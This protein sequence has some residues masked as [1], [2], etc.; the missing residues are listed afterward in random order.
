MATRQH[1]AG[2]FFLLENPL[3]SE[4]WQQPHVVRLA[5]LPGVY[6]FVLD[7][8]EFGGQV[9]GH[10]IIKPFKIM[11]DFPGLRDV[12]ERRL[13]PEERSNCAPIEGSLTSG[14]QAYPEQMCRTILGH[15]REYVKTQQPARF[16]FYSQ[17]LPVQ[18]PTDDLSQWDEIVEH[19]AKTFERSNRRPFTM[20]LDSELGRKI[21]DLFRIDAIKIQAVSG[22]TTRRIPSN[23]DEYYTRAAFFFYNDET[24]AVEVED[25]GD[26]QFPRQ[27]FSKPV[28]YAI[29]EPE[30]SASTTQSRTPTMVPNLP[31]DIDFPDLSKDVPQE[32]RSAVARLHLN[33]GHPSR[34]ELN[35]LLA[36]EGNFPD[37][38]YECARKLR[39]STCERLKPKQPPRPTAQ[40][41]MVVGQFGDEL[42]MDIFYCKTLASE[43]FMV[44]G[45]VDRATGLHQAIILPDRNS[46]TTFDCF[47]KVWLRPFGLP[48]HLSCDPDKSFRGSFESRVQAMGCIIEHC[49]PEAHYVIGMVERRNALLRIILEKFIYQFAASTVDQCSAL[50]A[51]SSHAINTGIHT[52]GRSAYQAVFGRQPRLLNGNLN[53]PMVLATSPS[54]AQVNQSAGFRAEFIRCEALKRLHELDCSQHLRR[55]LLR[56]TR[57]TKIADLQP[58]QAC[59]YWRWTRRGAKKRGGWV[60][61]RFLSWDPSHVGKQA[62]LRTGASTTLVTA[63]QL[64]AAFG[65]EDWVPDKEDVKA[66]KD[67]ATKFESFLDDRGPDPPQDQLPEDDELEWP[68]EQPDAE[69]P[70]TPSM[71][72][73]APSTPAEPSFVPQP[74]PPQQPSTPILLPLSGQQQLSL[75]QQQISQQQ[76][77]QFNIDS[78]TNI[79]QMI[80]QQYHRYGTVPERSRRRSRTPTLKRYGSTAAASIAPQQPEQQALPQAEQTA[81]AEQPAL[82]D[83]QHP[84]AEQTAGEEFVET[85][86]TPAPVSTQ[87]EVS[88]HA[89]ILDEQQTEHNTGDTQQ[90]QAP[91]DTQQVVV[92]PD[93]DVQQ[94]SSSASSMSTGQLPQKRPFDTMF[95]LVM[96]E[97]GNITTPDASWDGS[98]PIGFVPA[99]RLLH[100]AYLSSSQRLEDVKDIGKAGDESDTSQES[101]DDDL[102]A[103]TSTTMTAVPVYKQGMSRQE[104]KALDREIPWRRILEMSPSYID[105]FIEAVIKA[106]ESWATWESVQP[107]GAFAPG[108]ATGTRHWG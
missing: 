64:R 33:L 29:F 57:T 38:V 71:A 103:P 46:E 26:L 70:M 54:I 41:S 67:A 5:G 96:D 21:Q 65:F 99:P 83:A 20:Q 31:T 24:K 13:T 45:M 73:L 28:R 18:L 76:S 90:Q 61:A 75:S 100:K 36:Y 4:L 87:Q 56:K 105:K 22:P 59:A 68:A 74:I 91:T 32:V 2:R 86:Q 58:G 17:V 16:C 106:S 47:E 7:S 84:P 44:L 101:D 9:Q 92:V 39:C 93:D 89:T 37:A 63:E 72:V 62:W 55:A 15:L 14:S 53:D 104:L 34:Q 23:V 81:L 79:N 50:P 42:Q 107:S 78:P 1:Q 85:S 95:T 102:E 43:T 66:L 19:M 6:S 98:P 10:D 60:M 52:H 40:P 108:P 51:A 12:L 77:V 94:V 30:P 3:K 11:T 35:R 69:M 82:H 8:G 97:Q 27:R 80:Q 88:Q 25:L 48:I 49:P